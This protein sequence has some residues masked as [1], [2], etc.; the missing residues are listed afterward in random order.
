MNIATLAD[1]T[2]LV[3]VPQGK[4]LSYFTTDKAMDPLLAR[5]RQEIDAF[6]PDVATPVGRKAIASMAY[7]VAQSKTYLESVGKALADE[8][9]EIPKKIDAC[10]KHLRDTL[11]QWRDEVRKPLTDW[12]EAEEARIKKHTDFITALNEISRLAPGRDSAGLRDSLAFVEAVAIGP[13][14]EEFDAEYA[15]AKDAARAS[16]TEELPKAEKREAEQAELLRLREE[17]AARAE[18]DRIEKIRRDAAEGAR[19][20]ADAEAQRKIDA[21][22][23]A[24]QHRLDEQAAATRRAEEEAAAA[25]RREADTAA[26]LKRE[27]E[28]KAA[29]EKADAEAREANKRHCAAI[30]RKALKAFEDGGM[31]EKQATLAVTLIAQKKIP[32]VTIFY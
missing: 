19:L 32:N 7:T 9:K 24:A 30:N 22:R 16:L 26:R 12:E 13:V 4:A 21:E 20:A 10:R 31:T 8:Q 29:Q 5:I 15:R 11:D 23:V 2:Q 1:S 27:A 25:Q 6:V 3:T 28:E 17:S 14:C 18:Q